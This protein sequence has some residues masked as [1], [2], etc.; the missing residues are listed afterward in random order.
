MLKSGDKVGIVAPSNFVEAKELYK[1]IEF[2]ESYGL[3]VCLGKNVFK[4]YRYMAGTPEE[5]AADIN[6][7]FSDSEIKAVFCARGG[8]GCGMVL[9]YL[10]YD[11]IKNNPKPVFGFSD[12]TTLQLGLIS[13]ANN[14]CY[15]GLTLTYEFRD[16]KDLNDVPKK[17]FE[18]IINGNKF[19]KISGETVNK[20]K[21]EGLLVGGCFSMLRQVIGTD[22]MPEADNII[23]LLED[24]A[25][26]PYKIEVGLTQIKNCKFFSKVKGIVFG[27]FES[28]ISKD[29]IDGTID[30][31]INEFAKD[32]DIPVIK[33][34]AY[35][36]FDDKV[37]LPIGV[38]YKLD[39]DNC[40]LEE[41][42]K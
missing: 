34:F 32:L 29:P 7:F 42:R 28:C 16:G 2:L 26:E 36:H 3:N 30:D 24:I 31:V 38:K 22:Y 10:D 23:L 6:L 17:S 41:E 11:I 35:G 25:E 37:V 40:L 1:G 5:R 12:N 14:I 4:K 8:S 18:E 33:N 21:A 19:S 15:T 13:K 39:A 20:G 9:E 27:K